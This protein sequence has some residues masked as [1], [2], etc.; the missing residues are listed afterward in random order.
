VKTVFALLSLTL[1]V[2]IVPLHAD[3][4]VPKDWAT[5]F[6]SPPDS[7]AP[8]TWW[9]WINGNVSRAGITA[10]LE[11]MKRAGIRSAT[12]VSVSASIPNGN[13]KFLS[14][15]WLGLVTFA[16][17]EAQ[18]LGLKIG[19]EN[20]EGWSSSGGPWIT[21]A[22]SMQQVVWSSTTVPGGQSFA[23]VL[24]RPQGR[25]GYYEDIAVLAIPLSAS[26]EKKM[27]DF[28]PTATTS[29]A[30]SGAATLIDGD[31]G[32]AVQLSVSPSIDVQKAVYGAL[33]SPA[34]TRDVT[35]QVQALVAQ[36]HL[37]IPVSQV[38]SGQDPAPNVVKSLSVEYTANGR[39][40]KGSGQEGSTV[41]LS[42]SWV[43]VEFP[44][45]FT[46]RSLAVT[47]NKSGTPWRG[48]IQY[49]ADGQN[50]TSIGDVDALHANVEFT[51]VAGRFFRVAFLPG[52]GS[53]GSSI[54]FAELNL[55]PAL[56]VSD[57]I[58]QLDDKTFVT[59]SNDDN[60]GSEPATFPDSGGG[61]AIAKDSIVDLTTDMD[62]SGKL[63]W[64]A[65]AGNW[66]VIRFGH[67]TT[68]VTNHPAVAGGGQGLECDKL[69]RTAAEAYWQGIMPKIQA[70]VGP[71]WG[72]TLDH[73]LIDSYEVGTQ[74]WTAAM[75]EEFQ[76]RCGYDILPYLPV[77]TGRVVGSRQISERF[78]WDFRRTI[79]DLFAENY[80]DYFETMCQKA[81]IKLE[82]EPYGNGSFEELRCAR[83][84]DHV[85]GE[86][87]WPGGMEMDDTLNSV[88][89]AASTAHTYGK[90]FVGAEAFTAWRGDWTMAPPNMKALGDLAYV[91]G[92]NS[93]TFHRYAHQPWLD[94]FPGMTMG[95]FGSTIER[96]NNW[97][98]P[99]AA[100]M[101]YQARCNLLLRQ[102]LFVADILFADGEGVPMNP[103]THHV[104]SGYDFD[105]C[106]QDVVLHR[107]TVKNGR[108]TLPDGMSYR[109]LV[110][111]PSTTMTPQLLRKLKELTD[112][113]A[114][115][116]G[117]R[118][119]SSP[120]LVDYPQCDAEVKKLGEELWEG[121]KITSGQ[122]ENDAL[123]A[124]HLEPDFECHVPALRYIHRLAGDA[125]IYFI[126]NQAAKDQITD[127]TFRVAG[128]SP[129]LWH[130][131]TGKMEKLASYT[132]TDGRTRISLHLDP[133]GSVFVVFRSGA[134]TV[135][136][137]TSI[138]FAADAPSGQNS[139][140]INHAVYEDIHEK[141]TLD[142]TALLKS[143]IENGSLSLPVSTD[144]FGSD[145]APFVVK[146]LK[147]DYSLNG[148]EM[149]RIS[150]EGSFFSTGGSALASSVTFDDQGAVN[151]EAGQNG[152]YTL[153]TAAGKTLAKQVTDLP[154]PQIVDGTWSIDFPPNLGAPANASFDQLISWSDSTDTGIKYFSGTATYHNSIQISSDMVGPG[155]RLYLDLG[156][157]QVMASVKLNN[158]SLGVLWKPPY[159]VDITS[160]AQAGRN[161]LE[162]SV[163]NL[164][165]NR[166]IGDEQLPRDAD[167]NGD[168]SI[169]SIPQWVLDGKPSPTGRITFATWKHYEKNSPLL[170]SGLIGPVSLLPAVDVPV[171]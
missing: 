54:N 13:V 91:N 116:V 25:D 125:D 170:P 49:S 75:P 101:T 102:G 88:R 43:Q 139:L 56:Q 118:P 106:S 21:P 107:L 5:D 98:E 87:W 157:V 85:M 134:A 163:T 154:A 89:I 105:S 9:H 151:L 76:K 158:K 7:V 14:D 40:C 123:A 128:K 97:W 17:Q 38:Y 11:A 146:Q 124:L 45:P 80:Y 24:P 161:D 133:I 114:T 164:W 155:H 117:T 149:T 165:P 168:G 82:V 110:L 42:A 138:A 90:S 99:G 20:C 150:A 63:T 143:K 104:K 109:V 22:E 2:Q 35:A 1:L 70:A 131:D 126:S 8:H 67:T 73:T 159:R 65:P 48:K 62:A 145:P 34:Q 31:P 166:L 144:F 39:S 10:D 44:Q 147:I 115:I 78:L 167:W 27:A 152:T 51:P 6:A 142:V 28:S 19:V 32:T 46:A 81:G 29:T 55:S 30:D 100:W 26:E 36:G 132:E 66:M 57:K 94:R 64:Q 71:L 162:V 169:K 135:D 148:V 130:P 52:E 156:E 86:F 171:Q 129:E 121:G 37:D 60:L 53:G 122:T 74:N 92:V 23:D 33:A 84:T 59:R 18:R 137:P 96:T 108:L 141:R 111:N 12:I 119:V 103:T 140:V 41:P 113:G 79:A 153:Q 68:G 83:E 136:H 112:G 16:A 61:A 160:A 3:D 77:L 69:S 58:P 15:D 120:S 127:C 50:F 93:F 4:E 47:V 72:T 95:P